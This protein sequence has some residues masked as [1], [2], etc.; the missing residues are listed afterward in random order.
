MKK[1]LY[2]TLATSFALVACN[3]DFSD[4]AEPQS[5]A[6]G[7]ASTVAGA[8]QAVSAVNAA[9]AGETIDL[10]STSAAEGCHVSLTRLSLNGNNLPFTLAD[11]KVSVDAQ[12]LAT[13]VRDA[14]KSLAP[15]TRDLELTG[16]FA[17]VNERGEASPLHVE[18]LHVA[19]TPAALPA[20]AK[21]N[22]YYYVGGYNNWNLAE[23]TPF[24]SKGDGIF[25]LT[26]TIGDGE[27][28]AFA[29]QSAV[30]TQNWDALFRAPSNGCTDNFG[31]LD[32]DPTTGWSFN[33]EV[34][35]NYTFTL[36]MKNYTFSYI[37]YIEREYYYIGALATDKSI[38]LTNG[39][40]DPQENPVFTCT[41][42]AAGGWHWFKIAP[43]SG[44][45]EDG[46]WNWD[47]EKYCA[48]AIA[49]D[50]ES[51]SGN[52]VI[53]GDK[54]SWHL[55]EELYPAKFYRLSFN[56]KTQEYSIT[57]V[58][59]TDYIYYAGDW[60]SWG[61]NKKEMALVDADHGIY[62]GF[63]WIKA[64]DNAS[65]WGFKFIDADGN[66]YGDGGNNTINAAG[67]N[68]DPGAEGFYKIEADW[69]NMTY[70]LTPITTISLI[71]DATGDSSWGTDLDMTWTGECWQYKGHLEAGSFKFRANH[72]W[73][74]INW[75][76]D[77]DNLVIDKDNASIAAAGDYTI[78][79]YCNCPGKAYYTIE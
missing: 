50:D 58:N 64:V 32:N 11:G 17:M 62:N 25:E 19:Y 26:I 34:G 59:Y 79:L 22:A 24:E 46:S 51:M 7:T 54:N 56:F 68:M 36:D 38:P 77:K 1:S 76:G 6:E 3:E 52:F 30:D 63:Y 74:G 40:V 48:C 20:N 78:N 41:I 72:D 57:P 66:W 39:G 49:K 15:V 21:E 47:N 9:E 65:T 53:G 43:G 14:Y 5:S 16:N 55:M 45:N 31:Y 71:G 27:W 70:A 69:A 18:P 73:N 35:G 44:F 2:L 60:T 28:F 75:G 37:N 67:G 12:V 42:P 8:V 23:P 29:P 61:D 13:S 4:W 10:I 33:C